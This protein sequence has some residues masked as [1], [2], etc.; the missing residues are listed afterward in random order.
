M[1]QQINN[2][3]SDYF[4]K[5]FVALYLLLIP[6][7]NFRFPI[8]NISSSNLIILLA[9]SVCVIRLIQIRKFSAMLFSVLPFPF[10]IGSSVFIVVTPVAILFDATTISGFNGIFFIIL[11]WIYYYVSSSLSFQSRNYLHFILKWLLISLFIATLIGYYEVFYFLKYNVFW[12]EPSIMRI[13]SIILVRMQGTY[14]DPNYF[15]VMPLMGLSI[16]LSIEAKKMTKLFL[17]FFFFIAVIF[18]FSRMAFIALAIMLL[19]NLFSRINRTKRR[20]LLIAITAF[21]IIF[22]PS[23]WRFLLNMNIES[24]EQR[25]IILQSGINEFSKSPLFGYG[26]DKR[27]LM[28]TALMETHN[29]FLQVLLYGGI[30]SFIFIYIP[31]LF[32]IILVYNKYFI[33]RVKN[34]IGHFIVTFAPVFFVILFFLSYLNL[35]YFWIFLFLVIQHRYTQYLEKY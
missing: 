23:I 2:K 6:F 12:K 33:F 28:N 5:K 31:L 24:F 11:I 10:L 25:L 26:F 15:S 13:N 34:D 27:V 18:T 9:F 21:T 8:I 17:F 20:L 29:T 30:F 16:A 1:E 35:K 7:D 3:I 4:L 22:I 14:F 32:H 19:V